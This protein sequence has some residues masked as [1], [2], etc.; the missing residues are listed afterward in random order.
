LEEDYGENKV[1]GERFG[2][3]ELEDLVLKSVK[4][5]GFVK[6][7][8]HLRMCLYDRLPTSSVWLLCASAKYLQVGLSSEQMI[9]I[10]A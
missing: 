2:T 9:A 7:T 3:A 5:N 4:V 6:S 10:H 1:Y 8:I